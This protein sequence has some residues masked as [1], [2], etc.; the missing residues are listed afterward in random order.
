MTANRT[1]P[2]AGEDQAF[3]TWVFLAEERRVSE[4]VFGQWLD[5]E[6]KKVHGSRR[7][8]RFG[9]SGGAWGSLRERRQGSSRQPGMAGSPPSANAY[10][11]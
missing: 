1:A 6:L 11:E 10:A 9:R 7:R 2:L 3:E 4:Q 8:F 5:D